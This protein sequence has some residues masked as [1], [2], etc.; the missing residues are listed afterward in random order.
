MHVLE[1][2]PELGEAVGDAERGLAAQHLVAA[3]LRVPVGDWRPA[4]PLGAAPGDLGF[5]V[6]DGL[7]SR[8]TAIGRH[9]TA[10][11]LGRGDLLGPWDQARDEASPIALAPS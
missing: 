11:L 4:H 8:D 3:E 9:E 1:E 7:I 2:D 6:L 5:L 10:E